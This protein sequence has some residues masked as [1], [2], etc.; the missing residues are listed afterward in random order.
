[1]EEKVHVQVRDN[2]QS[3]EHILRPISCTAWLLGVGIAHPRKCPKAIMI[4]IR[5][6]PMAVC[7]YVTI[8][9]TKFFFTK[10]SDYWQIDTRRY[11]DFLNRTLCYISAFYYIY[12]G[13]RQYNKWPELM[14]RLKKLD[15]NIRKEISMNDRSIKIIEALALLMTFTFCPLMPIIRVLYDY[16]ILSY[17]VHEIFAREMLFYY[18]LAQ[19]L[20][21]SFVFDVVVY[22]LYCR[23]QTVNKL[24]GQLDEFSDVQ[25]VTFKIR[26]IREL[27]A[28]ICDL[29]NMV[30][31]IHG[32]HLLLC[33]VN[34][35]IMAVATSLF[36]HDV[37]T[38]RAFVEPMIRNFFH[39]AYAMQ[40]CLICWICTLACQES[41]KTGRL[42]HKIILNCKLVNLDMHEA[43][44]QSSLEMRSALEDLNSEQN[45]NSSS[46]HN[47]NYVVMENFLHKHLNRDCFRN[48]VNDF[49]T[50]LQQNR[51]AF[52][53][54]DFF[55]INNT[56]FCYV[57]I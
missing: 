31:D 3:I 54:C 1:M 4:I 51:V 38:G 33:S 50:Q 13:I 36:L 25:C 11:L 28:D 53:A 7:S 35:F 20:I 40:F 45:S 8:R 48:E 37:S 21:N 12:H 52:T 32:L 24:I 2:S 43:S 19:S 49:S 56:S 27:H 16:F 42:I 6:I 41:N 22:V 34:C 10:H 39:I 18:I 55:E 23:F 5:I 15:Q 57:S 26:R 29:A 17:Q 47:L 46:S 44:N 30:N 9:D 14:D